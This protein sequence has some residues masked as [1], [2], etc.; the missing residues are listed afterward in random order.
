[1]IFIPI[2]LSALLY[3]GQDDLKH[4]TL[5]YA[6]DTTLEKS[7]PQANFGREPGLF[8]GPGRIVLIRFPETTEEGRIRVSSASLHLTRQSGGDLHLKSVGLLKKRWYEGG[9]RSI[10]F[11]HPGTPTPETTPGSATWVAARFKSENWEEPGAGGASDVELIPDATMRVDG[12][13][14]ILDGLGV[15]LSQMVSHPN[16][17]FGFRLEFQENSVF[18]S[19]EVNGAGP[20]LNIDY[21]LPA[22][23]GVDA[24]VMSCEALVPA[25]THPGGEPV[26]WRA[27]VQNLGDQPAPKVSVVWTLDGK[28][29][30]RS[31]LPK[32]LVK[33][34]PQSVDLAIPWKYDPLNHREQRLVIT[35]I[36]EGDIEPS[37]DALALNMSAIPT[38]FEGSNARAQFERLNEVELPLSRSSAALD[39]CLE[40]FRQVTDRGRAEL[41]VKGNNLR[42]GGLTGLPLTFFKV[43]EGWPQLPSG[44]ESVALDRRDESSRPSTRALPTLGWPL[45]SLESSALP[46][47]FL[48]R[49][50]VNFL[51]A[52]RGRVGADRLA[53]VHKVPLSSVI[54]CLDAQGAGIAGAHIAI[55]QTQG[56][57]LADKPIVEGTT[58]A[59]GGYFLSKRPAGK[60]TENPFG[61]I[62]EDGSN[63]WM[64]VKLTAG[65]ATEA[66]WYP[67]SMLWD[68]A[69]RGN[70]SAPLF[71]F[72]LMLTSD[73]LD[74]AKDIGEGK[75]V[76]DSAN[77]LPA[78]LSR[79]VDGDAKTG[80]D[81]KAEAK[82]NWI[83]LDLGRDR[84]I[85]EVQIDVE[86]GD[87]FTGLTLLRYGTSQTIDAASPWFTEKDSSSH[88]R[89]R[90][91]RVDG[92]QTRL[93]YRAPAASVRYLR[94]VPTG[95][96][97]TITGIH[98]F[99]KAG[100]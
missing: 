90:G 92:G 43:P 13:D 81:F 32:P 36:A 54:W 65:G 50:E 82:E 27:M 48:G 97:A 14:V 2:I 64:L 63:S 76:T 30:S 89:L 59:G 44:P 94:L 23:G 68:E 52:N 33:G 84:A 25:G 37:N 87:F 42:G 83:E 62:Q 58:N 12:A 74:R 19:S 93:I 20:K 73:T 79:L 99:G 4:A 18:C 17:S 11:A 47:G 31:P 98:V 26:T 57:G 80:I 29:L 70:L 69:A 66:A 75:I 7:M 39:G 41:V 71:E 35:V 100:S 77:H 86:G 15:A 55:F 22:A 95:G 67:V 53:W 9:G 8:G 56:G 1:M 6:Q 21:K 60:F 49:T 40:R 28:E 72:R 61:E 85:G 16:D 38:Y 3:V 51:N 34:E 24:T 88:F 46:E 78:E 91:Q 5:L 10:N 45:R 96:H